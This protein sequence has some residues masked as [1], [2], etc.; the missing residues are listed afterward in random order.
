MLLLPSVMAGG[1]NNEERIK[2]LEK[3]IA[4]LSKD[5][6]DLSVDKDIADS[7]DD[8]EDS[9]HSV[10]EYNYRMM[11]FSGIIMGL[12]FSN[13]LQDREKRLSTF[14]LLASSMV[15]GIFFVALPIDYYVKNYLLKRVRVKKKDKNKKMN[16]EII[17]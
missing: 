8:E 12:N 10:I 3:T 15:I 4:C 6:K 13:L 16:V 9:L 11:N 2:E 5:I 17:A 1:D 14:Y 7:L